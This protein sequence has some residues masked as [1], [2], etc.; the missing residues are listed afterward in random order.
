MWDSWSDKALNTYTH[1][2]ICFRLGTAE[3]RS[4]VKCLVRYGIDLDY[5]TTYAFSSAWLEREVCNAWSD[6]AFSSRRAPRNARQSLSKWISLSKLDVTVRRRETA[7]RPVLY[8]T[9]LLM[10]CFNHS[11]V[12]SPRIKTGQEKLESIPSI[13]EANLSDYIIF[14]GCLY[15]LLLIY[16]SF[17]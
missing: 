6:I 4:R 7:V 14:W 9:G 5:H 13:I 10:T 1:N 3:A 2:L 15:L 8:W 16:L 12:E 17:C 11:P